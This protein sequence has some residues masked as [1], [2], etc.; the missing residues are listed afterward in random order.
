MHGLDVWRLAKHA[1][2]WFVGQRKR[3]DHCRL[4]FSLARWQEC[5]RRLQRA[6]YPASLQIF[7]S[8]SSCDRL[9]L[10]PKPCGFLMLLGLVIVA[11]PRK[12]RPIRPLLINQSAATQFGENVFSVAAPA[13]D[14][15]RIVAVA[16]H[17]G[18][19][20]MQRADAT[21][22]ATFAARFAQCLSYI[23]G[24]GHG[25]SPAHAGPGPSCFGF[26]RGPRCLDNL[27]CF[28]FA[29]VGVTTGL[30]EATNASR[31]SA[32]M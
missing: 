29:I 10:R 31:L 5:E 32:V 23:A 30:S 16:Q 28:A 3:R 22:G 19:A 27:F 1:R 26:G 6:T 24:G 2:L 14:Q 21:P 18:M 25:T 11:R 13:F 8:D 20:A 7:F 15:Q 12:R 9:A 4:M 17:K